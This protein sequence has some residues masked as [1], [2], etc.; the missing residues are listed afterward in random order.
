MH[1]NRREL[2]LKQTGFSLERIVFCCCCYC[3]CCF[4][5]C[6]LYLYQVPPRVT[7]VLSSSA[8]TPD[9]NK[10]VRQ[11]VSTTKAMFTLS[12]IAQFALPRKPYR[13][14]LL[15]T[16]KNGD[17]RTNFVTERS[18]AAPFS[19]WRV[20]HRTCFHTVVEACVAEWLTPH[21]QTPDL[22]VRGSSP[23]LLVVSLDKELHPT[24]PVLTQVYKWV[25]ATYCWGS[26]AKSYPAQYER[27]R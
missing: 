26:N 10:V 1:R 2:K 12:Q 9:W 20:K 25:P 5:F 15:I 16:Q 6:L 24:L 7:T 8:V 4:V 18:Y 14:E 17:F 3:C 22:E 13:I 27:Q 23:A 21:D 19:K 11:K